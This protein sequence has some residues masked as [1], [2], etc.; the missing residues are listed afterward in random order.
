MA[1]EFYMHDDKRLRMRATAGGTG[2][3]ITSTFEG[4]ASKEDIETH[5]REYQMY[6]LEADRLARTA[7]ETEW[8][9]NAALDLEKRQQEETQRAAQEAEK[10]DLMPAAGST[11]DPSIKT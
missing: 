3:G 5:P 4:L 10:K 8:A 1:F 11:P 7:R 6:L 2:G 9:A